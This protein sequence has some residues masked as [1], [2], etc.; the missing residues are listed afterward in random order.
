MKKASIMLSLVCLS[1]G[2][3]A[4]C[5]TAETAETANSGFETK[6]ELVHTKTTDVVLE[7]N[8]KTVICSRADYSDE[9]L[10][11]LIPQLAKLTLLDHQNFRAGAPC[12][13][14][15]LCAEKR[16]SDILDPKRPKEKTALTVQVKREL[17]I[18]HVQKTCSVTLLEDVSTRIRGLDFVHH[19][20]ADLGQRHYSDCIKP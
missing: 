18:D 15:T 13:A 8:S 6:V 11:V 17:T 20:Q 1:M 5:Q 14:A 9:F 2:S 4:Q 10:K 7:L 3:M 12:V 19:R 16:P